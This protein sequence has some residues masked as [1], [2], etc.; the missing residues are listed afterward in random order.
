MQISLLQTMDFDFIILS[1]LLH[2]VEKPQDFLH[3][4]TSLCKTHTILHIN[5]PNAKSF[6]LVW[7]YEA[8]LI[9]S[10]G[11]LSNTAKTLQQNTAFDL[12]SLMQMAQNVSLE[13]KESGSYFIKPFNH[14]KMSALLKNQI[15]D[16]KLLEGL[17]N[18]VKYM[19]HL[20]AEIFINAKRKKV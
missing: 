17:D 14:S 18:M 10:L 3:L 9:S 15:L 1:S 6:H 19:P 4:I 2:E 8:G 5:V 16:E 11:K 12:E 13:V 7:A 20:G